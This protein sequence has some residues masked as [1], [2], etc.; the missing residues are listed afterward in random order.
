GISIGPGELERAFESQYARISRLFGAKFQPTPAELA[1]IRRE[2]LET[3][4]Q[5]TLLL[6]RARRDGLR[7]TKAEIIH[8][9]RAVPAFRSGGHFSPALYEEVL[10]EENLTPAAFEH[11][12]RE[13]LLLGQLQSGI[14]TTS[15]LPPSSVLGRYRVQHETRPVRWVVIASQHF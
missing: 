4:I 15:F 10:N 8:A 6:A 2:T 5:R 11:E 7:V 14:E 1:M 12:V 9:I 3:L 13:S